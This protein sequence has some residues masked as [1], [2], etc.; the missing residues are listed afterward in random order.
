SSLQSAQRARIAAGGIVALDS[1]EGLALFDAAQE[2][3]E[4][5]LVPVRLDRATL[6]AQAQAGGVPPLLRGLFGA[7]ARRLAE[8]GSLRARLTDAPAT[9]RERL[10]LEATLAQVAA[11]LHHA[12]PEGIDSRQP[13]KELGFDSLAAVE[14]RNRLA[15]DSGL[16]LPATLV[17]DHPTPAAVAAR[18]LDELQRQQGP[19]PGS[20]DAEIAELERRLAALATDGDGRATLAARL[21]SFLAGLDGSEQPAVADDVDLREAS[22]E[23]ILALI[24]RELEAG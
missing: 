1:Q 11:V 9:E 6:R 7:P 2:L 5:L 4:A 21:R 22:A 16:R 17:F 20:L 12:S 23:Q 13:F 14:L 18:L 15:A 8:T 3:D 19:G 24:D 10:V